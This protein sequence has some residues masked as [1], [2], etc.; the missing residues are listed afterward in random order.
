MLG[1]FRGK[2]EFFSETRDIL[3]ARVQSY[4]IEEKKYLEAAVIGEIGNNSFDH[5]FAFIR[6]DF[7]LGVFFCLKYDSKYAVLA[8]YGIGIRQS[9]SSVVPSI[10]SDLEAVEA[11]FTKRISGRFPEQRGNGLKFVSEAI[12]QNQWH[13]FLQSGTGAC[14]IDE[15]GMLFQE[16]AETINGCLAI[17]NFNKEN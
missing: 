10:N 16:R 3:S 12:Q 5:N 14:F 13:F 2:N 9:L 8:D 7:P 1:C 17:M 15:N 6:N 11:A 4:I